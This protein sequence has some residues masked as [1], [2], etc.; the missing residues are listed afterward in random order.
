MFK[1]VSSATVTSLQPSST[2]TEGADNFLCMYVCSRVCVYI[3]V[4]ASA[5]SRVCMSVRGEGVC[6]CVHV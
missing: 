2:S 5:C 6:V 1:Q 4:C 3:H